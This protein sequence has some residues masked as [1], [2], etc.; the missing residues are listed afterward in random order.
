M[1]DEIPYSFKWNFEFSIIVNDILQLRPVGIPPSTLMKTKSEI[2]LHCRE[3]SGA[4]LISC[5]YFG[6]G[7]ASV[8]VQVDIPPNCSPRNTGRAQQDFLPMG[9]PVVDAMRKRG[10]FGF[11]ISFISRY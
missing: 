5:S 4:F 9:I 10:I 2:L 7:R 6:L 11:G 1:L 8:K 3:P